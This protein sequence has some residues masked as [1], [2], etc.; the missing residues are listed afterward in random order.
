MS[1]DPTIS[2]GPRKRGGYTVLPNQL[3]EDGVLTARAYGIFVYLYGRPEGWKCRV[4][5]L[6]RVF[7]EG[8]DAI[9]TALNE[10]VAAG[11]MGKNEVIEDGL[12][13]VR[14]GVDPDI[15]ERER[16]SSTP[17]P[18]NPELAGSPDTDSQDPGNPNT[19][20]RTLATTEVA[21]TEVS[22]SL[23]PLKGGESRAHTPTYASTHMHEGEDP[24]PALIPESDIGAE[25]DAKI[26]LA[27]AGGTAKERR[28]AAND[29]G[30]R[31]HEFLDE[32]G[33]PFPASLPGAKFTKFAEFTQMVAPVL[34]NYSPDEVWGALSALYEGRSEVF[35]SRQALERE[36]AATRRGLRIVAPTA[37]VRAELSLAASPEL[38]ADALWVLRWW[39]DEQGVFVP[40]KMLPQLTSLVR[41]ALKD[42]AHR[43]QVASTL[44]ACSTAC[45]APWVFA[46]ALQGIREGRDAREVRLAAISADNRLSPGQKREE[47]NKINSDARKVALAALLA[48]RD[49]VSSDTPN[50]QI[51]MG[52]VS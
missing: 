35:P 3:L 44:W 28:A 36:L 7:K 22:N 21:T 4:S 40:E 49:G 12:R 51:I 29:L 30:R 37:G 50:G 1:S 20:N 5:D 15:T 52:E 33:T 17:G 19:G 43:K 11:Y 39:T 26:Q 48:S 16:S 27:G 10:L 41:E 25:S 46:N 23:S 34:V 6:R 45:P 13:R 18:G 9:Y 32:K 24:Q 14:Y 38:T 31:W 8:R 47:R 2:V 42:G